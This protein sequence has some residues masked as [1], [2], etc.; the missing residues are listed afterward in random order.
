MLAQQRIAYVD[1]G[2][3]SISIRMLPE[4]IV[5]KFIGGRGVNS[6]LLY[7]HLPAGI[8][9]LDASNILVIGAGAL[10]GMKGLATARLTIS[11]KSPESGLLGDANIGGHFG[12]ALKKTG[13]SY[14]VISGVSPKPVCIIVREGKVTIE[15]AKELWGK[16]TIESGDLIKK[17]CGELAQSLTIGQAG[18]RQVRFACVMHGK[19]NA[20]GRTGMGCVMGAKN[21]KAI[22]A[23]ESEG[24]LSPAFPK[25]FKSL[26]KELYQKVNSEFIMGTFKEY[27]TAHLY[28]IIN[29]AIGM[30]RAYNGLNS[31]FPGNQDIAPENLAK[32]YYTGKS[33]CFSCGVAC[34][35]TYKIKEG[36]FAGV[37]NEG[38][39]YGVLG[40]F[41][42]LLGIGR[43]EPILKINDLINRYG[44][45]ASSTANLIACAIELFQEGVID[46][47]TTQG[48]YLDWGEEE[49]VIEL[50]RKIAFREGFGDLLAR[51]GRELS[52][53]WQGFSD[54]IS[55]VKF[56]PQSDPADLRYMKAYAL[57]DAVATR[58]ADHLRSR[59]TWEAFNLPEEQLK[60]IY[61]GYVSSDYLSYEGKGRVIWWWESYLALFDALGMCKLLA[62]HCL[63]GVFSFE[64]FAQLIKCGMGLELSPQEVFEVGE[65]ITT[66]ERMFIAREG[67]RRK[68]DFPPERYFK[69]L[70]WTEGMDESLKDVKLDRECFNAMLDEYY[71]LHGWNIETGIPLPETVARLGLDQ[72]PLKVHEAENIGYRAKGMEQRAF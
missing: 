35:H 53:M 6:Y 51:G 2:D 65:R 28:E 22:V 29:N 10:T 13:I 39:E 69:P 57:G 16:D 41:G 1:L 24:N 15:D 48:M 30:G 4:E 12:K 44:L 64:V 54:V 58:G 34:K 5:G 62:F 17:R 68:D 21:L 32:H 19:K 7:H 59:P 38:P 18:E 14:L 47:D 36:P 66:I 52:E 72:K 55:W 42:P 25:E 40:H 11:G 20:A 49:A 70:K 56:L 67:V 50:V 63:P 8:N 43:L 71:Q 61:G 23:L 31:A 37:E 33:P 3:G 45:D 26:T 9:P 27:G 60:E 46:K